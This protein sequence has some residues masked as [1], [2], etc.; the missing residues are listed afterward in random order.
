MNTALFLKLIN[1]EKL[2]IKQILENAGLDMTNI[3]FSKYYF[4]IDLLI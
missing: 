4:Y 1:N 3:P 2:L